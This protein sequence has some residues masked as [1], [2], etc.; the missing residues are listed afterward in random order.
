MATIV[1]PSKNIYEIN[2]KKI[3]D[4]VV[5]QIEVGAV[6]V[7]PDN[8]YETPVYNETLESGIEFYNSTISDNL[9]SQVDITGYAKEFWY[10]YHWISPQ[11]I[12]NISIKI[13]KI[14]NNKWTN[15]IYTGIKEKDNNIPYIGV[16]IRAKKET[17]KATGTYPLSSKPTTN[18]TKTEDYTGSIK[19]KKTYTYTHTISGS[20]ATKSVTTPEKWVNEDNINTANYTDD[21]DYYYLNLTILCGYEEIG[22]GGYNL[23]GDP[24]MQTPTS[25]SL[26]GKCEKYTAYRVEITVYGNTIGID[27]QDKTVYIPETA[28]TTNKKV[29]S[30]EGNELM[31]TSNY[32]VKYENPLSVTIG[33]E[34]GLSAGISLYELYGSN[35]SV[36]QI[37]HYNNEEAEVKELPEETGDPYA[38]RIKQNGVWAKATG[39]TITAYLSKT[40]NN[41]ITENYKKTQDLYAKGKETATIRCNL[42]DYYEYDATKANYKGTNKI[43]DIANEN[44]L[45]QRTFR[46][47][48]E[49]VPLIYG[50]KSRNADGSIVIG[51]IPMSLD[52]NGNP[53]KFKVL[54]V[55]FFSKGTTWQEIS[56]KE[57]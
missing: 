7:V 55:K 38:I 3:R 29:I 13:P 9:F 22:V 6:E 34:L 53:K 49:V 23:Y 51:D 2:N 20:L 5:G 14:K 31:Q 40:E 12:K 15:K 19:P 33:G 4:N 28:T 47:Y 32:S 43:I 30:V 27:L 8:K 50:I 17:G 45:S 11:Y 54:G 21:N 46:I 44:N 1:I 24:Y 48:D 56:L 57:A 41:A 42:S 25:I 36:G 37:L 18:Y 39:K 16:T 52:K 35:L 26:S 10:A